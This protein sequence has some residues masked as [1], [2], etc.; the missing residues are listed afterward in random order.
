M[1]KMIINVVKKIVIG[2][3]ILYGFN[4]LVSSINIIIPINY[5]TVGTVSFLG[6]PGLLSLVLLFFLVINTGDRYRYSLF[7][8]QP[9]RKSG[10]LCRRS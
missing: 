8:S 10:S 1:I 6:I 4:L 2:I 3:F 7:F 5:I 9:A